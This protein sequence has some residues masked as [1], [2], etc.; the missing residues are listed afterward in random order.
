MFSTVSSW[1]V[2][3]KPDDEGA[4]VIGSQESASNKEN[5]NSSSS[6]TSNTESESSSQENKV[7]GE[8]SED[9]KDIQAQLD[10][11]SAK[12][13]NT[14]KEWGGKSEWSCVCAR[15]IEYYV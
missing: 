1:F 2:G 9:G 3:I 5:K 10:E 13:V 6:I 12:A 15:M 4:E 14:A 11:M 8:Q 7:E